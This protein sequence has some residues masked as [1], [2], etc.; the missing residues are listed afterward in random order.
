M[1]ILMVV[2]RLGRRVSLHVGNTCKVFR[3]MEC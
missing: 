1:L 2:L 3:V